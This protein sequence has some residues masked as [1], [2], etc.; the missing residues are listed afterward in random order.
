[1]HLLTGMATMQKYNQG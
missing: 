1:M